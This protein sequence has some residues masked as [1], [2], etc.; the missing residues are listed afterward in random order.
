MKNYQMYYIYLIDQKIL[1]LTLNGTIY[2][3]YNDADENCVVGVLALVNND[4]NI[5]Y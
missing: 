1:S 5:S 3:L 2:R 4:M